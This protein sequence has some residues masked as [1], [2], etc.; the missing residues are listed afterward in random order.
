[1][2]SLH[3]P[4]EVSA[5][6]L[7]TFLVRLAQ[8]PNPVIA[9][10]ERNQPAMT[11][12]ILRAVTRAQKSVPMRELIATLSLGH[13]GD[14]A[15]YTLTES[16]ITLSFAL[17]DE[18]VDLRTLAKKPP[19]KKYITEVLSKTVK[20]G[21]NTSPLKM[22]FDATN[23]EAVAWA[24]QRAAKLV[25]GINESARAAIREVVSMGIENGTT[26]ATSAKLIRKSIGLTERDARAVMNRQLKELSNGVDA[27]KA[28]AR[29]EKY[30]DKLLRRRAKDIAINETL[31]ASHEGQRQM[32]KQAQERGL[33]PLSARKKWETNDPC[34]ICAP[35]SGEV[36]GINE[37]FSIGGDPPAHPRCKCY[38]S[39]VN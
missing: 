32:W 2:I 30:A 23:P 11:R 25:S 39:L 31:T 14:A 37:T 22:R 29:A 6:A 9:A 1:M 27:A 18:V 34:P 19:K 33:I 7:A 21:A 20:D 17:D 26:P 4:H 28:T 36:V 13:P 15:I 8:H 5:R 12:T 10:A 3:T 35:L 16:L 24:R 38:V